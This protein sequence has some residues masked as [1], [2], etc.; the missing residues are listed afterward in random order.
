MT[1]VATVPAESSPRSSLSY[2]QLGG[3]KLKEWF[4]GYR[5]IHRDEEN[6]SSWGRRWCHHVDT[7]MIAVTAARTAHVVATAD[8]GQPSYCAHA[9]LLDGGVCP[10]V[11]S[12]SAI[13]GGDRA[14]SHLESNC[15]FGALEGLG[16][17]TTRTPVWFP[18][19]RAFLH[20]HVVYRRSC[21]SQVSPYCRILCSYAMAPLR[22][23]TSIPA[24]SCNTIL[25][26]TEPSPA[27]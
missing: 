11:G 14:T 2:L 15:P 25:L 18:R 12:T 17:L 20:R 4:T 23:V 6:P 9:E 19:F 26:S 3:F 1:F 27:L 21:G 10:E 22:V 8:R 13:R 24:W 7:S 5:L 16:G